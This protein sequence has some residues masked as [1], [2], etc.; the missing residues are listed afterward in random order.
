MN[1]VLPAV[2][3]CSEKG[4]AENWLHAP[5]TVCKVTGSFQAWEHGHPALPQSR[6][7]GQPHPSPSFLRGQ[8]WYRPDST[9]CGF[10]PAGARAA[11]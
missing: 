11:D 7:E 2:A 10:C 1:L 5:Y 3:P 9:T 6:E 8:H 4:E